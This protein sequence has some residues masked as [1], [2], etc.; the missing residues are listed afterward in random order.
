[1]TGAKEDLEAA[2]AKGLRS[3]E[4]YREI[5]GALPGRE[6]PL[7]DPRL[8][9]AAGMEGGALDLPEHDPNRAPLD[10]DVLGASAF[11]AYRAGR[12]GHAMA[13]LERY[14]RTIH[15][16]AEGEPWLARA[17]FL[18]SL[19]ATLS[20]GDRARLVE[21]NAEA[22]R[23]MDPSDRARFEAEI[24]AWNEAHPGEQAP[25]IPW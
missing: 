16:E 1:M 7:D 25:A 9:I 3:V 17:R 8:A 18:A 2:W 23:A 24:R 6:L 12:F 5:L 22:L 4:L 13:L 15:R 11:Q 20:A 19:G 10:A 14:F 21:S